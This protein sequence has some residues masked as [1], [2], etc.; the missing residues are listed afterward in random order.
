MGRC[1]ALLLAALLCVLTGCGADRMHVTQLDNDSFILCRVGEMYV[2]ASDACRQVY[3]LEDASY[4]PLQD[5]EFAQVRADVT[6][7][8]GGEAGFTGNRFLRV[9]HGYTALTPQTACDLLKVPE[10]DASQSSPLTVYRDNGALLCIFLYQ[11]AY[12]IYRDGSFV[13][14]YDDPEPVLS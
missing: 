2:D 7:Y 6:V 5:G 14:T 11:G 13:G 8:E 10:Y 4:P 3:L 9:V 12:R 1:K